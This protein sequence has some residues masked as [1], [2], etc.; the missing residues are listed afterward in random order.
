MLP[1]SISSRPFVIS[2]NEKVEMEIFDGPSEN[3]KI[4]VD[5]QDDI[6]VPYGLN[7]AIS[8]T[9]KTLKLVHPKDNDFF[10]ACR[11]KLGWSLNISKN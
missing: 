5:G 3:A 10:E 6:D 8:K 9:E 4:C 2:S 11:E 7:I 1:Q